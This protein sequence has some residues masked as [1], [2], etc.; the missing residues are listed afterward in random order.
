[1]NLMDNVRI[2]YSV[3]LSEWESPM[4][5]FTHWNVRI[6]GHNSHVQFCCN[7]LFNLISMKSALSPKKI[8]I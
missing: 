6:R 8:A 2:Q 7:L 5:D 3:H 1:M 4:I